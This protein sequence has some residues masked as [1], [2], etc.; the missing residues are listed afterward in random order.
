MH[1]APSTSSSAC[2][3]QTVRHATHASPDQACTT[4]TICTAWAAHPVR[5]LQLQCEALLPTTQAALRPAGCTA[6]MPAAGRGASIFAQCVG[7]NTGQACAQGEP[8]RWLPNSSW[9]LCA[10]QALAEAA[11]GGGAA[12]CSSRRADESLGIRQVRSC[13]TSTSWQQCPQPYLP[14]LVSM[15]RGIIHPARNRPGSV[16]LRAAIKVSGRAAARHPCAAPMQAGR[17]PCAH[18]L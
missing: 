17:Q 16:G 10:L 6:R 4:C 11:Q 18:R 8:L 7:R 15:E 14:G 12:L 3:M 1:S 5:H 9:R 2:D 13:N